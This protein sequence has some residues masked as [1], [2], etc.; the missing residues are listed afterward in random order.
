MRRA[1]PSSA[2]G[3]PAT[4]W[5]LFAGVLVM[6]LATFV[7]PFLALFLR[8]RG[9]SATETGLVVA[10][11]GAGTIPAG[12]LAGW[13]A[14]RAGRR[15]TLIGALVAAA[16]LTAILPAVS[17]RGGLAAAT[18]GLGLAVNAYFPAANAVV[19]DVVRPERYRDAYGLMYWERNAGIAVSF[20]LGGALASGGYARLFLA[21]AVTTLLFAAVVWRAIPETRPARAVLAGAPAPRKSP[22]ADRDLAVLLALNVA[23]LIPLYQFMVALPL[24][25]ARQGLSPAA[26]GLVM[27]VNGVL[28]V[29]LQPL[30]A[31]V[32]RRL[33]GGRAIAIASLLVAVGYGGYAACATTAGYAA[34]TAVW[35]LGEIL[36]M[37]AVS[38]LVAD[39]SPPEL[40]GRYQGM[41]ALSFGVGIA[42]APALGGAVLERAGPVAL[43]TGAA[44]LSAAVGAGHLLAGRARRGRPRPAAHAG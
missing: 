16:L 5:W 12:P 37:P 28:I 29:L 43:F 6:A 30:S 17:S 19:A 7:F 27:A 39:L 8:S 32:A 14:D 25:M 31:P 15:P 33:D 1:L 38:S 42:L 44:L 10:L 36:A 23:F 13:L 3:L 18:L 4:F 20:A 35:T 26:Y 22:L 2:A 41:L 21:D 34:C 24:T 9:L 40:R 11:F